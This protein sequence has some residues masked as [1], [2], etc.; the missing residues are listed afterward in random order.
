MTW[1]EIYLTNYAEALYPENYKT[2][3]REIEDGLS[4]AT[5]I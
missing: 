3:Q 1:L 2:L 4:T 5:Y